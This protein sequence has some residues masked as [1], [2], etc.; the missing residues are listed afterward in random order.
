MISYIVGVFI[1]TFMITS[2]AKIYSIQDSGEDHIYSYRTEPNC[3][4]SSY[5][6]DLLRYDSLPNNMIHGPCEWLPQD[7]NECR[8]CVFSSG[9]IIAIIIS[10]LMLV[11]LTTG[12]WIYACKDKRDYS[13]WV[14]PAIVIN[15]INIMI[16]YFSIYMYVIPKDYTQ[17]CRVFIKKVNW[18]KYYH[19]IM[20]HSVIDLVHHAQ[21]KN[22]I[23]DILHDCTGTSVNEKYTQ[24]FIQLEP[25]S[26]IRSTVDQVK[27][28]V[29]ILFWLSFASGILSGLVDIFII[30]KFQWIVD[31]WFKSCPS[32][33]REFDIVIRTHR[34]HRQRK[35]KT[36][37]E[38][39]IET[40]PF[41][42]IVHQQRNPEFHL[43]VPPSHNDTSVIS[44]CE[45]PDAVGINVI[46]TTVEMTV[47]A[48][49]LF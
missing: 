32:E 7:V 36:N 22:Q 31:K 38:P 11:L 47:D 41:P 4:N 35:P 10:M 27:Y 30:Y 3:K 16:L 5:Q 6:D 12:A 19:M 42:I 24:L 43:N 29:K 28:L 44:T 49:P 21:M 40:I 25:N 14:L 15:F 37:Q 45:L 23:Q 34:H 18:T 48:A 33:D 17:L 13:Y 9:V 26:S 8:N 46:I 2:V 20:T 39:N 1:M